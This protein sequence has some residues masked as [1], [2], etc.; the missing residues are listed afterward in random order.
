VIDEKLAVSVGKA[1]GANYVI[2]G[3]LS[4]LES[5]SV[6][7]RKSSTQKKEGCCM[8]PFAQGKGIEAIA[9]SLPNYG[10]IYSS[11]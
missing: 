1:A 10:R 4:H 9:P 5:K 3:S 2:M 6:S 7:T 8:P 11:R